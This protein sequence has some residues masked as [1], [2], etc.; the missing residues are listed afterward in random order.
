MAYRIRPATLIDLPWIRRLQEQHIAEMD[1]PYPRFESQDLD[2]FVR[3]VALLLP[4]Q[5][6]FTLFVAEIGRAIVG[7]MGVTIDERGV[8]TP[9]RYAVWDLLYV[10]P[11]HR[12]RGVA[13]LLMQAAQEW[14]SARATHI[15]LS[16]LDD[17]LEYWVV[18]GFRPLVTRLWVATSDLR[19]HAPRAQKRLRAA[20]E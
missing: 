9:T 3:G 15:E 6:R 5:E 20:G 19:L 8:G 16:A 7:M 13:A 18:R 17:M 12:Q 11:R 14:T 4:H 10:V 1:V 2:E